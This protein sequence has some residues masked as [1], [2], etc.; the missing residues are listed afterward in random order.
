MAKKIIFPCGTDEGN[1]EQARCARVANQNRG[2]SSSC[3]PSDSAT[4]MNIKPRYSRTLSNFTFFEM[5]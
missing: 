2:F 1:P 3:Q 5:R 4:P